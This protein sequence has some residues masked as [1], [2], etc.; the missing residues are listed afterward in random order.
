MDN[1]KTWLPE[2]HPGYDTSWIDI[3]IIGEADV[4][5]NPRDC[6]SIVKE[7]ALDGSDNRL[8]VKFDTDVYKDFTKDYDEI[9]ESLSLKRLV[10]S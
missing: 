5:L 6:F 8:T 10:V 4:G 3:P 1:A 2:Y 9:Y 7:P